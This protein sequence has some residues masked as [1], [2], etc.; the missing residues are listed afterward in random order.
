MYTILD[1]ESAFQFSQDNPGKKLG[2]W[3]E[4]RSKNLSKEDKILFKDIQVA[5]F[6]ICFEKR[7]FKFYLFKDLQYSELLSNLAERFVGK[8]EYYDFIIYDGRGFYF[9][10]LTLDLDL[11]DSMEQ[12]PTYMEI[13]GVEFLENADGIKILAVGDIDETVQ[14]M[15]SR[16]LDDLERDSFGFY[17]GCN[18]YIPE[19]TMNSLKF[20]EA[21]KLFENNVG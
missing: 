15:F 5:Q 6:E 19:Q 14:Y 1:I 17:N 3:L 8:R 16:H 7:T 2:D 4:Y 11:F 9:S 10:L 21:T 13:E 12:W 18:I 20:E